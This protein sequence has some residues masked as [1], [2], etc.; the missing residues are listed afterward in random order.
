MEARIQQGTVEDRSLPGGS[1]KLC[2]RWKYE[3]HRKQRFVLVPYGNKDCKRKEFFGQQYTYLIFWKDTWWWRYEILGR[4]FLL[5][6][7]RHVCEEGVAYEK[8]IPYLIADY[9]L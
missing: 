2:E 4:F 5:I 3:C 1:R 6:T 9:S 8:T 7:K